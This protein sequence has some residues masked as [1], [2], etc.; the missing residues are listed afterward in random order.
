MRETIDLLL[1][2]YFI[3]DDNCIY[4]F[5]DLAECFL[6]TLHSRT[7]FAKAVMEYSVTYK[8]A[9]KLFPEA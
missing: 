5:H 8:I 1:R 9:G 3:Y 4:N 2:N 6:Q 7:S